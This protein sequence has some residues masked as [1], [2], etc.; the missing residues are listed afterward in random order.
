MRWERYVSGVAILVAGLTLVACGSVVDED[1]GMGAVVTDPVVGGEVDMVYV[2]SG[3]CNQNLDAQIRYQVDLETVDEFNGLIKAV[4]KRVPG[5]D[6]ELWNPRVWDVNPE[7]V[8]GTCADKG[9][10]EDGF[11]R[12]LSAFSGEGNAWLIRKHSDRDGIAGIRLESGRGPDGTVVLHFTDGRE[13]SFMPPFGHYGR[14][15]PTDPLGGDALCWVLAGGYSKAG[16]KSS[17]HSW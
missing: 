1:A 8:A 17:G 4:Q 10:V 16:W 11:W 15:D 13:E 6:A 2:W 12:T 7:D 9:S 5:C 14:M 3:G